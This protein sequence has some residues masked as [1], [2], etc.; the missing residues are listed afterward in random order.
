MILVLQLFFHPSPRNWVKFVGFEL[1]LKVFRLV[2]WISPLLKAIWYELTSFQ[3]ISVLCPCAVNIVIITSKVIFK[4]ALFSEVLQ[5]FN[6]DALSGCLIWLF[7]KTILF[8]I[9]YNSDSRWGHPRN[10]IL[11]LKIIDFETQFFLIQ[12]I[13]VYNFRAK[14]FLNDI[15]C[16]WKSSFVTVEVELPFNV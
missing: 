7:Y 3:V 15:S 14:L 12:T 10:L 13:Y 9:T 1:F 6:F 8:Q 2:P 11:K 5:N 16:G 4:G